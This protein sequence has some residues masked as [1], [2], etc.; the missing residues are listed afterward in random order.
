[1]TGA[2]DK[3]SAISANFSSNRKIDKIV[4]VAYDGVQPFDL[5]AASSVFA[6]ANEFVPNRY[7]IIHASLEGG[8]VKTST[9]IELSNLTALHSI[10]GKI[11]TVL[12]PGGTEQAL[13]ELA[14]SGKLAS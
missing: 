3:S 1:M 8:S 6:R 14:R 2:N 11:N 10:R 9:G 4:L 7:R 5:V 12:V 13:R